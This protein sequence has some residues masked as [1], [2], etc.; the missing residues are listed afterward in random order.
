MKIKTLPKKHI[1]MLSWRDMKHPMKG[2]AE[3]N[4]NKKDLQIL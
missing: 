2:E 4:K 1:L 3:N